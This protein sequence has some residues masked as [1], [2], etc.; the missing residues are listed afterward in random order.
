MSLPTTR[1]SKIGD[2]VATQPCFPN[3]VSQRLQRRLPGER[4]A[5]LTICSPVSGFLYFSANGT[6]VDIS[7]NPSLRN[8][9]HRTVFVCHIHIFA[10]YVTLQVHF[11]DLFSQLSQLCPYRDKLLRIVTKKASG[12]RNL[13]LRI[14]PYDFNKEK[15]G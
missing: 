12:F 13:V 1:F 9:R 14:R 11:A 4:G 15:Q 10:H 3:N 8:A 7:E 2:E 6:R 5:G